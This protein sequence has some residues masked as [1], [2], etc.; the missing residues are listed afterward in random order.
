MHTFKW[1]D[2]LLPLPLIT[3]EGPVSLRLGHSEAS[4]LNEALGQWE[5]LFDQ[6]QA[7]GRQGP[8]LDSVCG[9]KSR[10]HCTQEA[11]G[12][13]MGHSARLHSN[14]HQ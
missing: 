13:R 8:P 5:G 1:A 2:P 3:E 9:K 6:A 14:R 7:P 11:G 12:V 10:C 4:T